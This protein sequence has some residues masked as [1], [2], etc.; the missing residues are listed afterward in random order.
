MSLSAL[1]VAAL[2]STRERKIAGTCHTRKRRLTH[3]R[4][5]TSTYMYMYII[6]VH[7]HTGQFVCVCVC[8]CVGVMK[9][10]YQ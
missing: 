7:V 10:V 3:L 1:C 5:S 6:H 4:Y 8:V 2:G 9:F